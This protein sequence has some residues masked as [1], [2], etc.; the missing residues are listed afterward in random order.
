MLRVA[1]GV[2]V[3]IAGVGCAQPTPQP[4]WLAQLSGSALALL[5]EVH[6]NPEHHRLR[7]AALR[8]ALEAGWRPVIVMEQF[9]LDRQGDIERARSERP[10]DAQHLI[11]QA[12]GAGGWRWSDYQAFVALA[13]QYQL[14]LLAGNLSR[15]T[16]SRLARDDYEAVLGL[17]QMRAW[18]LA[19]APDV[20]WQAAQEREIDLG[21]CG[22]LPQRL[23]NGMARGQFAR[24]AAMAHLLAQHASRGAV[25]LAGN[26]HVRR[27]LGVPRW[28]QRQ[29]AP[30]T[31]VVGFIERGTPPATGLY[32]AVVVTAR[33]E[34]GDPC[35][36]FKARPAPPGSDS[37]T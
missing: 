14:P 29:G 8:Q 32:D 12:R 7:A 28:L 15:A 17:E 21:H 9:D 19:E 23:W 35:E 37:R 11:A 34:R 6:D 31:L 22:A 10:G 25:L 1:A 30:A 16:T 26:G 2:L 18:R 33:A 3:G 4:D 5:G 36:A 27:D 13:L 24:D 20:A